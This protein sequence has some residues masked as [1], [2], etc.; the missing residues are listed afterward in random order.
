MVRDWALALIVA[1]QRHVSPRK[2][3]RCAL[4]AHTG[5]PSCSAL[6]YRAIR[7][8]GVL[9]GLAILRTRLFLCGVAHRRYGK[10]PRR[11]P[12]RQRGDCDI[13]C[14]DLPVDGDCG[15]SGSG[16]S[17]LCEAARCLD[18]ATCDWPSRERR[19]RR[20]KGKGEKDVHLPAQ[21]R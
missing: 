7:M 16:K 13:G 19:E 5:C 3:Y 18:S 6:G 9:A 12:L 21:K 15:G 14:I 10:L 17:N 1:Y 2:G 8:R 11:P 20:R 4:R